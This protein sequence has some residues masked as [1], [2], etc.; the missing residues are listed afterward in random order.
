MLG[1]HLA[2]LVAALAF[3]LPAASASA[4]PLVGVGDASAAMFADANW[5][6]LHLR[7]TRICVPY[8]A[9]TRGG[10]E[11]AQLD[12]FLAAARAHGVEPMVAFGH[13]RH[14]GPAPTVN[15]YRQALLAFRAAH[16]EV[17]L[18][19]PWNEANW[20]GQPTSSN[21]RLAADYY[22]Q[23]LTV[24]PSARTARRGRGWPRC[25]RTCEAEPPA[26]DTRRRGPALASGRFG[27]Q[28]LQGR[29]E[30]RRGI[31]RGVDDHGDVDVLRG[32]AEHEGPVAARRAHV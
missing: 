26:R 21:P 24:F 1:R 25:A 28:E 13:S 9:V 19:T 31:A 10:W 27:D 14:A 15:E 18:I 3:A 29:H 20:R 2:A 32:Q 6:S 11:R 4:R 23:A 30:H 17:Q 8:D 12:D 5:Q 22:N 16:P 7:I